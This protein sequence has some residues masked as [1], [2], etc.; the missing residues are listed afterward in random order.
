MKILKYIFL[1]L[2]FA[3]SLQTSFFGFFSKNKVEKMEPEVWHDNLGVLQNNPS[4]ISIGGVSAYRLNY[5][6]SLNI[7]G[8]SEFNNCR[9]ES[10]FSLVGNFYLIGCYCKQSC[11]FVGNFRISDTQFESPVNCVGNGYF[12][13][14]KIKQLSVVG[15]SDFIKCKIF[16][17]LKVGGANTLSCNLL[18]LKQDL[19]FGSDEPEVGRNKIIHLHLSKSI[20][21]G[22]VVAK[23]GVSLKIVK[24]KESQIIGGTE[25]DVAFSKL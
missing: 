7:F 25:G 5:P 1:S 14:C 18:K 3:A 21:F 8:N 19:I 11:S 20:V 4:L 12:K 17:S 13:N 16:G 24:D 9:F 10:F 23:K 22:K 6:S 2:L 15:N